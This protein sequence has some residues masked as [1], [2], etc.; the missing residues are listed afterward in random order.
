MKNDSKL[1]NYLAKQRLK[2]ERSSLT[3]RDNRLF[4]AVAVGALVFALLG[5]FTY[6]SFGPGS[7]TNEVSQ[8]QEALDTEAGEEPT[9]EP[10]NDSAVPD[11]MLSENR[12]WQ[13]SLA[14]NGSEIGFE[15][16]GAQAPQAVANFVSL[17][18]S[19]YFEGVSCHRLVTAGIYVLQC[20]DPDGTGAG[21]PGYS[22]GPIE[23]APADD[24]YEAGVIA[25]ARVGGNDF[26]MGSQFFIVYDQSQIPSDNVGGYTIFGRLTS[27]IDVVQSI[28]EK[29]TATQATDGPPIEPV[30]MT[31]ISVE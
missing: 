31:L 14:L 17:T 15:L 13:G 10:Q 18:Q 5:Q 19:G 12:T 6:F 3:K 28:A 20:G 21:G 4:P 25:M 16:D 2:D 30:V 11:P 27:G 24:I 1:D 22:W 7:N 26:S 9:E 8:Q 23:N 29:G